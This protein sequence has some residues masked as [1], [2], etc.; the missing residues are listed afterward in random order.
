MNSVRVLGACGE[1]RGGGSADISR[2]EAPGPAETD[3]VSRRS[4]R[5]SRGP[6]PP[7][8]P[9]GRGRGFSPGGRS[10]PV[11]R[12]CASRFRSFVRLAPVLRS[13]AL[14][15]AASRVS[16][17]VY[18]GISTGTTILVQEQQGSSKKKSK[19]KGIY[20]P[21]LPERLVSFPFLPKAPSRWRQRQQ[22]QPQSCMFQFQICGT[23]PIWPRRLRRSALCVTPL[24]TG[25]S[26]SISLR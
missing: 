19:D 16:S 23:L 22:Q 7:L 14:A 21:P 18:P 11:H 1:A 12:V 26:V 13:K 17:R 25:A 20:S 8:G 6:G 24:T 4:A 9:C 10:R 15:R 5:P 2:A 3:E